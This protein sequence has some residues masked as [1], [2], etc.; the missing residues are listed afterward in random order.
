MDFFDILLAKK[1][2]GGKATLIEKTITANGTYNAVDDE[3]DGY[4]SVT[5]DVVQ[6]VVLD[7]IANDFKLNNSIVEINVPNGVTK[8]ADSGLSSYS[9]V[10]VINIPDSCTTFGNNAFYGCSSLEHIN[11]PNGTTNILNQCFQGCSALKEI[12]LPSS[13]NWIGKNAFG[14]CTSLKTITVRAVNPPTINNY[15]FSGVPANAN[16][17]V[18]A[19]SVEAYKA[20]QYWSARAAYIQ[21]IQ[22]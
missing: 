18:P 12:D 6:N 21:A 5:V 8:I 9:K 4:S 2:G 10:K 19:E 3:A 14:N 1:M 20:A 7:Y 16:I 15:S 17:Y 11:I 13:V 22:E